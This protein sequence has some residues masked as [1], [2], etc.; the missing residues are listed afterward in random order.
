MYS[1]SP[2]NSQFFSRKEI[3]QFKSQLPEDYYNFL[4]NSSLGEVGG[5]FKVGTLTNWLNYLK[6]KKFQIQLTQVI[7]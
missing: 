7:S 1:E 3:E 5:P 6:P 4:M 2:F